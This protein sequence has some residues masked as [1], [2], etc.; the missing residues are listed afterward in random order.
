MLLVSS[1]TAGL[2]QKTLTLPGHV[3]EDDVCDALFRHADA[4]SSPERAS[5]L[6][7][8]SDTGPGRPVADEPGMPALPSKLPSLPKHA[9]LRNL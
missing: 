8:S 1:A 5:W 4:E 3:P 7:G 2:A 9:V 6:F